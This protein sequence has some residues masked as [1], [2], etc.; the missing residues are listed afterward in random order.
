MFP[1]CEDELKEAMVLS[2]EAR[3]FLMSLCL[4]KAQDLSALINTF[5]PGI[6]MFAHYVGGVHLNESLGLMK[7]PR[8]LRLAVQSIW[9]SI[10]VVLACSVLSFLRRYL[11][12]RAIQA[13]V[14]TPAEA[15]A[16]LEFFNKSLTRNKLLR[17]ILGPDSE[18]YFTEEGEV[19]ANFY[20]LPEN[21]SWCGF[22]DFCQELLDGL[23][24][25]EEA[26]AAAAVT[27]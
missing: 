10:A 23:L 15:R 20:E 2:P 25:E 3:S 16:A 4:Q 7:R 21:V 22:R 17:G 18:Y 19:V 13:V 12:R 5:L 27:S 1:P 14:R 8:P 11:D 6:F 9:L 26:I 24:K